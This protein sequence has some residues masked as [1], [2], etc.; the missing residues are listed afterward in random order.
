MAKK[1][2]SK[3]ESELKERPKIAYYAH[4][5]PL[6][7]SDDQKEILDKWIID[8]KVFF[9][10]VSKFQFNSL[11]R[12]DCP[13]CHKRNQEEE[14]KP[15]VHFVE[16]ICPD[17][18]EHIPFSFKKEINQ[19]QA[20]PRFMSHPWKEGKRDTD[21]KERFGSIKAA[22]VQGIFNK[23]QSSSKPPLLKSNTIFGK[24]QNGMVVIDRDEVINKKKGLVG[25]Y[26]VLPHPYED[27]AKMKIPIDVRDSWKRWR[28][29]ILES[30]EG[31]ESNYNIR[32]NVRGEYMLTV[33][34]N[35]K[36]EPAHEIQTI[37]G[38]DLGIAR[39][40]AVAVVVDL[41]GNHIASKFWKA[42]GI[43]HLR[44]T[45]PSRRWKLKQDLRK[46]KNTSQRSKIKKKIASL[47]SKHLENNI[48]SDVSKEIIEMALRYKSLIVVESHSVF[49]ERARGKGVGVEGPRVKGI[50]RAL[51]KWG[52]NY[53]VS[54]LERK[55]LKK[56]LMM[57]IL[58][59]TNKKED[60]SI[61]I[62]NSSTC[63]DCGNVNKNDRDFSA[64]LFICESCG[65]R[66]N[67]DWVGAVNIAR[68]SIRLLPSEDDGFADG[69]LE[70][71][72]LDV[73]T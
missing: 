68:S 43:Q 31:M 32:R 17:C 58:K 5:F 7:P 44:R 60:A 12:I 25:V 67:V 34:S 4:T 1:K 10:Y 50:N 23:Y 40:I 11:D 57:H 53:M 26:F 9:N 64:K 66:N 63:P 56:R 69:N 47:S 15:P 8:V 45:I 29:Y 52:F 21:L 24:D 46:A 70:G 41:D 72:D 16:P 3:D 30:M 65:Y 35:E 55:C 39:N 48:I 18:G 38:V 13:T 51:N 37:M 6:R 19:F 20:Y 33:N 14:I 42:G 61:M 54:L 27:R 49:R 59:G 73:M 28:M 71:L 36:V 2:D 22:Y 62:H